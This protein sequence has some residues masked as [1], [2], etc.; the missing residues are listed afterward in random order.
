METDH[1]AEREA[2]WQQVKAAHEGIGALRAKPEHEQPGHDVHHQM[3]IA[4]EKLVA[5][6]NALAVFDAGHPAA[7]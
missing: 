3:K 4:T 2:L 6:E 5:A 1:A 7:R